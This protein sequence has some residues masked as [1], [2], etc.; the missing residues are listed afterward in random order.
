MH[1]HLIAVLGYLDEAR[2]A[3][4]AAVATVPEDLRRTRPAPGRWSVAEVLEHLALV[5]RSFAQR[6]TE[7]IAEARV[8]GLG[9][10]DQPREPL[11]P[12]IVRR[13]ADR[14][15]AREARDALRP[16]SALD[17]ATAAAD[18]DL[19]RDGVRQAVSLAD[20]LALG[21][22]RIE[23]RIFGSLTMYQWV[24]LTAAHEM[25]HADQ[26]REIGNLLNP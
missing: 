5:D 26:I 8:A 11:P 25:R 14:S 16:T 12:A 18:L 15:E 6:I 4:R 3:I 1:P 2:G 13:M 21:S 7:A 20:G 17:A 23:H 10:E 19:A 24:E 22:V 9:P